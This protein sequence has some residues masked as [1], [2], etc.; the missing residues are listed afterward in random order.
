MTTYAHDNLLE[1]GDKVF[2]SPRNYNNR[3]YTFNTMKLHHQ[4]NSVWGQL[5]R[6]VF[7]SKTACLNKAERD[8]ETQMIAIEKDDDYL[9]DFKD[10]V[11]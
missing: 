2:W 9:P 6:D 1:K 3:G 8:I 7:M 4:S 11:K 5:C 10:C